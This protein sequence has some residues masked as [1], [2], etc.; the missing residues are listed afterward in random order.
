[1]EYSETFTAE[2]AELLEAIIEGAKY[3]M[4]KDDYSVYEALDLSAKLHY[5]VYKETK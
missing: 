2:K 5:T 3:L 1:M 4:S